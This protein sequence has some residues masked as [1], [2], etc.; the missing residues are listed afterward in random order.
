[1]DTRAAKKRV[2][3]LEDLPADAE[4]ALHEVEKQLGSCDVRVVETEEDFV[5]ALEEFK[6]DLIISDY[7][8]PNFNGM[9]ALKTA[10][11]RVP[12]IP[13]IIF[14]GSMNEETAVS[15]IHAGAWNYVI[16]KHIR[17][18]G[19]AVQNALQESERRL[20]RRKIEE[21]L[22]RAG[23]EW[24]ATFDAMSDALCVL[25]EA[26]VVVRANRA[27]KELTGR[28]WPEVVG[29][30][31]VELFPDFT[32]GGN[33]DPALVAVHT[34]S[35]II[36]ELLLGRRWYRIVA[37]PLPSD[38]Q[39]S[40]EIIIIIS[41]ITEKK[42]LERD[43]KEQAEWMLALTDITHQLAR[44]STH[45]G[46][47]DVT[48]QYLLEGFR[49]SF[50][51][52]LMRS[53]QGK[54]YTVAAT[55]DGES[56]R[57]SGCGIIEG[58]ELPKEQ[59]KPLT[60]YEYPRKLYRVEL[61]TLDDETKE[62]GSLILIE[63]L[64]A[65]GIACVVTLPVSIEKESIGIIIMAFEVP[66]ELGEIQKDYLGSLS[67]YVALSLRNCRLYHE[68]EVS[69]SE[70]KL[71][72]DRVME[73]NKLRSL[74]Q[75][76]GGIAH[77]IN[78]TLA[79]I[80]LYTGALLDTEKGMSERAVRYLTTVKKSAG[81][82]EK[83]VSRLRSFYRNEEG[84]EKETVAVKEMFD[85][86]VEMTRPRWKDM[87]NKRGVV[88][89]I[90]KEIEE[91]LS[92]PVA[93][94]SELRKALVN[95]V[96][97]AV[98]A[99]PE[100]G[101]IT[102]KARREKGFCVLEV[103]DTGTGMTDEVRRRCLEPFFTTKGVKGSGLGLSMVYG[104]MQRHRGYMEIEP[105]EGGGTVI[106]LYFPAVEKGETKESESLQPPAHAGP[107]SVLLIDDDE[108]VREVMEEMLALDGHRVF[109]CTGGEE[110][111]REFLNNR[112][113]E[114]GFDVVFTDLGMPEVDG[115]EVG[116]RIKGIDGDV[117]VILLTGWGAFL[118]EDYGYIDMIL[119]KPPAMA[120]IRRALE[121]VLSRKPDQAGGD[122]Y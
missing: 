59:I 15:C 120:S 102:L 63:K 91:G 122:V 97:N 53:E 96:L 118:E 79:P 3:I 30:T 45:D 72:R 27:F 111:V 116:R 82:I 112:N 106:G 8:L 9:A 98:D 83:I 52:V 60:E 73:Q 47:L 119:A 95:L 113:K 33:L 94:K 7:I 17:Q 20:E 36:K 25:N 16:K 117:P 104:M 85:D 61:E 109:A 99:M 100:G 49:C 86:V 65:C 42:I 5:T 4:L 2:L 19:P 14:T 107:L 50:A 54:S 64:K 43:L 68:L 93:D 71:A 10:V 26:G 89:H 58:G 22:S 57:A 76:A 90:S 18:L 44:Q 105:A 62:S 121:E 67:E 110:G 31:M 12:D 92:E 41:D 35:R 103:S 24:R 75:I 13:F 77:D 46:I 39:D 6:P 84:L 32:K 56:G 23:R 21:A 80:T 38:H 114:T 11:E 66:F 55:G 28:Q 51:A 88:I 81:D 74:G 70:L 48:I 101:T 69:Y 29:R 37:D 40:R 108:R 34:G 87:T 115:L 1:M 78:N